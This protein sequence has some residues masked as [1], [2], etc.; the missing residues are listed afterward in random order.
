VINLL[1]VLSLRRSVTSTAASAGTCGA[2][3]LAAARPVGLRALTTGALPESRRGFLDLFSCGKQARRPVNGVLGT[4]NLAL[5]RACSRSLG[6]GCSAPPG[7]SPPGKTCATGKSG[8]LGG[9]GG[10]G[11]RTTPCSWRAGCRPSDRS[12]APYSAGGGLPQIQAARPFLN[13]AQATLR[14]RLRRASS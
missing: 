3:I 7:P 11:V 4:D 5:L 2:A 10:A 13:L 12:Q 9:P 1:N 14:D 6:S 8:H